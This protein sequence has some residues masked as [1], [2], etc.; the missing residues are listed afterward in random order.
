MKAVFIV[1]PQ[2][3]YDRMFLEN[4]WVVVDKPHNADLFCFTGGEDVTPSLYGEEQHPLTY[5]SLIRDEK[6]KELFDYAV[7]NDIPCVGICRGGQFLNVMN[8]GKMYQHVENH[9]RS[10]LLV[11]I[12]TDNDIP[13]TSTH[14]QIMRPAKHG[15]LV[16]YA[17]EGGGKEWMENGTLSKTFAG[18]D[19]E[20]VWYPQTL[21]LC[22]QPHPEFSGYGECTAYFF[23]LIERYIK[24]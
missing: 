21:S 19:V 16:A 14:H 23:S 22:F 8:G 4:G 1:T 7:D 2:Y 24:L 15:V 12:E 5:A 9:C 10:H 3:G 13:V 6:E 11:D 18:P 17:E 20:V